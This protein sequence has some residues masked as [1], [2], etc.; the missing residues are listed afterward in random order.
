[1]TVQPA[2]DVRNVP[3]PDA[4][5]LVYSEDQA[6][7]AMRV[8]KP[9]LRKWVAMGLINPLR[10]P[11]GMRRRLYSRAELERFIASREVDDRDQ[12]EHLATRHAQG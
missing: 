1:M 7:K 5:S 10:V 4:D 8:S 12:G 2:P 6:A 3:T 9:T 11:D